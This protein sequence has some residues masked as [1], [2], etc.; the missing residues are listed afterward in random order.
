VLT[1]DQ[2]GVRSEIPQHHTLVI[3]LH[4][5]ATGSSL[6]LAWWDNWWSGFGCLLQRQYAR[7]E[8]CHRGLEVDDE[9]V[10][11]DPPFVDDIH[12]VED[13]GDRIGQ[14]ADARCQFADAVGDGVDV[15]A[16]VLDPRRE[17]VDLLFDLR[18][19]RC[20]RGWFVL[21]SRVRCGGGGG[22]L[23]RWWDLTSW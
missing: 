21:A 5:V 14:L 12:L 18:H 9:L 10:G 2:G 16:Q 7:H 3:S 15:A 1:L 22:G 19:P 20:E 6:F 13:G 23:W 8:I 4:N 17:V 11:V